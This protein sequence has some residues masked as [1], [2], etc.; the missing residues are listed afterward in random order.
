MGAKSKI[1]ALVIA[2]LMAFA[3]AS[4]L[5]CAHGTCHTHHDSSAMPCHA[6]H[7]HNVDELLEAPIDHS[8]CR[9]LPAVPISARDQMTVPSTEQQ[10]RPAVSEVSGHATLLEHPLEKF[11]P[12]SPPRCLTESLSCVL[13]I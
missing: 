5:T 11:I 12:G 8:C 6:G 9:I 2:L 7:A 4:R 3:P 10:G 1:V 13:L